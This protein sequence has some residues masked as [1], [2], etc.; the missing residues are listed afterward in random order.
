LT[1]P[2]T[3]GATYGL[4]PYKANLNSAISILTNNKNKLDNS[5]SYFEDYAT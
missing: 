2:L 5:V 4:I 1:R 3:S